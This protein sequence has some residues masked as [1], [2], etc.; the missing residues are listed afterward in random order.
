MKNYDSF[1][2]SDK[3]IEQMKRE[4]KWNKK[5]AISGT[6][7]LAAF[8]SFF[9]AGF[10][11]TAI[12]NAGGSQFIAE[13]LNLVFRGIYSFGTIAGVCSFAKALHDPLTEN[14]A[15]ELAEKDAIE[16]GGKS[17]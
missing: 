17:R 6:L 14:E 9:A 15:K 10:V 7:V 8:A 13:A 1:F 2:M 16:K 5:M 4:K 12:I 11:P 3:Q